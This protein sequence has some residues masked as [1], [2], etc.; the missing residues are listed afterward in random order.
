MIGKFLSGTAKRL[1]KG[2]EDGFFTL[3]VVALFILVLIIEIM[4]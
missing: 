1:L 4:N 2:H 3:I